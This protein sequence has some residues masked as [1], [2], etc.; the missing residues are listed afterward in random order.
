MSQVVLSFDQFNEDSEAHLGKANG[1][2]YQRRPGVEGTHDGQIMVRLK[3]KRYIVIDYT[4]EPTE[5]DK[6]T[7]SQSPN[8]KIFDGAGTRKCTMAK[9]NKIGIPVCLFDSEPN[10]TDSL[11][12]RSGLCFTYV[13]SGVRARIVIFLTYGVVFY[14]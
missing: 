7:A 11:Y 13:M 8:I 5:E 12:L 1:N 2:V 4:F 10:E 6:Q 9:C 14:K 3:K